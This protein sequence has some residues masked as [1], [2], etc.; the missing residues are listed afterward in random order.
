MP[1]ILSMSND[2]TV[3]TFVVAGGLC[4]ICSII[5]SGAA[6]GL[7]PKQEANKALDKQ[8]NVLEV[9]GRYEAGMNIGEEFATFE[10]RLVDL[11]TGKYVAGDA[12]A[13]DQRA[14]SKDSAQSTVIPAK[15][16]IAKIKRRPNNAQVF[17]AKNETGGVQYY[18]L[19]ISGYGLWS[20]MRGYLALE[21]DARTV[22]GIIFYEQAETPGLGGEIANPAW[23]ALWAGKLVYDENF[24]QRLTVV[25]GQAAR[26]GQQANYEVD[27]LA[28]ATLTTR[29][30]A[31][32]IEYWMGGNGFKKYLENVKSNN[33]KS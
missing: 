33:A 6:V 22:K 25:K 17:L 30:V 4:L 16:D 28:G 18:I 15:D 31:N 23:R 7:R 9:V 2:S 11:N 27:G 1:G 29:G 24:Q 19:P 8:K 21:S 14:A 20:T 5:V 13:F 32:L 3:K 26:T 10:P 12:A